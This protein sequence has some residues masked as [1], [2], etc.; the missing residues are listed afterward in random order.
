MICKRNS[1]GKYFNYSFINDAIV[2]VENPHAV[3][4]TTFVNY[5]EWCRDY[6]VIDKWRSL[7]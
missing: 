3:D 1:D 2:K 5:P 6:L 4:D 7:T